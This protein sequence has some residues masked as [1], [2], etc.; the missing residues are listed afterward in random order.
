MLEDLMA[1]DKL[2]VHID[3][4]VVASNKEAK[5]ALTKS[6]SKT[7][8]TML[9]DMA[10]KAL[11]KDKF[12]T[13]KTDKPKKSDSWNAIKITE[14]LKLSVEPKGSK[15]KVICELGWCSRPSRCRIPVEAVSSDKRPRVRRPRIVDLVKR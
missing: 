3:P 2:Y 10:S 14:R 8:D 4:I 13:K 7:I 15:V 11:P 9:V 12:S 6:L 1:K 5:T